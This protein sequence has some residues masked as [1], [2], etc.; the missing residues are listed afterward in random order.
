VLVTYGGQ[1]ILITSDIEQ[2]TQ[3][4]LIERYPDLHP[5]VLVAPHH[6]SVNTLADNFLSHMAARIILCSCSA[7]QFNRGRVTSTPTTYHTPEMGAI[8]LTLRKQGLIT[9]NGWLSPP[10]AKDAAPTEDAL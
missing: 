7:R 9:V 4:Q 6:G 8:T 1:T 5:D 10:Q 2:S 3:Q